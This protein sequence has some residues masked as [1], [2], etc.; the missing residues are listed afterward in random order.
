M[1]TLV[2]KTPP[3]P[4]PV[5]DTFWRFAHARQ[6]VYHARLRGDPAPWTQD[7][8][9]RAHRFTNCYRASD[10]GVNRARVEAVR[11]QLMAP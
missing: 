2:R 3:S 10:R 4:S 5:Y 11:H 7:E 8:I 6:Q 9:L 1:Y